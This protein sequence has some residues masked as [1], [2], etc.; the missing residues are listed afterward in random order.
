MQRPISVEEDTVGVQK[1]SGNRIPSAALILK[2]AFKYLPS[3]G[4]KRDRER[5]REKSSEPIERASAN[6]GRV[7][8]ERTAAE[9]T[10]KSSPLPLA[11]VS[12]P[13]GSDEF[14]CFIRVS[15]VDGSAI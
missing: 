7:T 10:E 2:P 9:E 3:G 5:E 11:T 14:L 12:F 8:S 4:G 1:T 15:F 6:Q 13:A